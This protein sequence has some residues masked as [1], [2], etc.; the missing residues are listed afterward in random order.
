MTPIERVFVAADSQIVNWTRR[1][2]LLSQSRFTVASEVGEH[3][4]AHDR[5]GSELLG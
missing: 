1:M 5:I 3:R 2:W 4:P